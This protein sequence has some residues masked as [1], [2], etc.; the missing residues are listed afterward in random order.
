MQARDVVRRFFEEVWNGRD[1][2]VLDEIIAPDCVTH[3]LRSTEASAPAVPRTPETLKH[4]LAEWFHSFPDVR[5]NV[6]DTIAEGDRVSSRVLMRG[7][8]RAPWMG[9]P[10]T[11]REVALWLSVTHRVH[12]GKIV[13]DWV[14][15]DR[16]GLLQ[17][18]GIVAD[19]P[20]LLAAA[21]KGR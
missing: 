1:L 7:T 4:E 13:E 12:A 15:V 20:S 3:Q 2:A 5:M 9:V 11:G 19:M 18:L 10:A 17:Q 21:G 6:E 14:L 8:H 16:L